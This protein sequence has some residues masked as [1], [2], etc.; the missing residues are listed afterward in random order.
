M[1]GKNENLI[2][3]NADIRF[4]NFEGKEGKFNPPGRRNFCVI[5]DSAVAK[6]LE[7]DG[8]NVKYLQP[9]EEGDEPLPYLQVTVRFDNRPPN[10]YLVSSLGKNRLDE[11]EVKM[12]DFA[13][14]SNVDMTISPYR[15]ERNGEHG[16]KAYLRTMYVTIV[17]DEL[18]YKYLDT[19]DSN[20]NTIGGCGNCDACDGSCQH[21]D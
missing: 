19:P 18:D 10:I 2:I 20:S 21:E 9:R 17:E 14:I 12:L 7:E 4:R 8:W 1:P 16:V 3:E 15:W 13:D 5:L 11:N 6:S